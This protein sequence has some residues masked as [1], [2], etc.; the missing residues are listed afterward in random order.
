[1]E[2]LHLP[3]G[4]DA[5]LTAPVGN[6]LYFVPDLYDDMLNDLHDTVDLQGRLVPMQGAFQTSGPAFGLDPATGTD[7]GRKAGGG[8]SCIDGRFAL[9]VNDPGA[10]RCFDLPVFAYQANNMGRQSSMCKC[11]TKA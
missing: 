8:A 4:N 10:T 9:F 3:G 6:R 7:P 2:V 5:R 1:M 11:V